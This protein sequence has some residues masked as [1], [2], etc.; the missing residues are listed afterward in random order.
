MTTDT[1]VTADGGGAGGSVLTLLVMSP[2]LFSSHTLPT[3]G[4]VMIGRSSGC[5]IC[6][7]DPVASREHARLHVE[8]KDGIPRL[9]IE[10]LGSANGTRVRD[11]AI[12][13]HEPTPIAPGEGVVI[14]GTVVIVLQARSPSGAFRLWS[15]V[16]FGARV[17]DECARSVA[18]RAS[19]GLARIRFATP[20]M[21]I[22][23][24]L[25][26]SLKGDQGVAQYGPKDYELLF[27]GQD[28]R[29]IEGFMTGLVAAFRAEG[30]EVSHSIAWCPRD[31]KN[32]DA[33]M[34]MANAML[35]PTAAHPEPI[36]TDSVGMQRVREMATKV[37]NSQINVL[38]R[39]ETGVGKDVLA[40]LI[41]RTS[42]RA[43]RPFL[44]LNCAAL[45]DTLLESELFGYAKGT[46]TGATASKM[47]LL[48]SADGGTVFLDE[49]GD[50]P[51]GIQARLLRVIDDRQI[52][53]LGALQAQEI[54]VR[55]ISATNRDLEEAVARR[56]FRQD[57]LFRLNGLCLTIPPLRERRGEIPILATTFLAEACREMGL[58]RALSLDEEAMTAL[59]EHMWSGNIREL[60]NVIERAVVLCEGASIRAEHLGLRSAERPTEPPSSRRVRAL[61]K[62]S[63]PVKL[64][65]RQR[66]I[67]AL[68]ACAS[69]QT[70]AARLLK[71]PRRTF[72]S[73]LE[74]YAIPRPQKTFATRDAARPPIL[75]TDDR[76]PTDEDLPE[77]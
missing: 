60:K 34:T 48:A 42:S 4:A 70:R 44:A 15:H 74:T 11:A 14:G 13:A 2:G 38:I 31:G 59:I 76:A 8:A 75:V 43:Q 9:S 77:A 6:V 23:P 40:R 35:K 73:K 67:D 65:E 46:F 57:L 17:E 7:D 16:F 66:I 28:E 33:L 1:T 30:L 52:R 37:A 45:S 50:M 21:K 71:M 58:E 53:P 32:F 39:G 26:R 3:S 64:A 25:A 29:Q 47:G 68:D 62:L 54:N 41:H 19:V 72:V 12:P 61:P 55:F 10:D 20:S 22:F 18:T 49:V 5:A 63:D 51:L 36:A 56:E 27:T 69:N 24:M